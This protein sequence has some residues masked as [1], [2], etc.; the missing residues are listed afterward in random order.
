MLV[1]I[2]VVRPNS[3]DGHARYI[4]QVTGRKRA[5]EVNYHSKGR[6]QVGL[7]ACPLQRPHSPGNLKANS[8]AGMSLMLSSSQLCLRITKND[9]PFFKSPIVAC[10]LNATRQQCVREMIASVYSMASQN[11][12]LGV[13]TDLRSVCQPKTDIVSRARAST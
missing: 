8:T 3:R 12:R 1:T 6:C 7:R 9:T 4:C 11:F 5:S 10:S 13:V 2:K